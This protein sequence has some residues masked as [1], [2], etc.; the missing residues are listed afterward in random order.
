MSLASLFRKRTRGTYGIGFHDD[1]IA[2]THIKS[3]NAQS[4]S[5]DLCEFIPL[6]EGE[7]YEQVLDTLVN[8]YHLADQKVNCVLQPGDYS[9]FYLESPDVA[10]DEL[11][12]AIKWRI[13]DL[14]DFHID[15]AIID[16]FDIPGQDKKGKQKMMYTIVARHSEIQW[17][18]ELMHRHDLDINAIDIAELA[19]RNI[20]AYMPEDKDGCVLI[21]FYSNTGLI[22][23]TQNGVLHL[24]RSIPIGSNHIRNAQGADI[25][26]GQELTAQLYDLLDHVILEIQRSLDYFE[27]HSASFPIRKIVI[28]PMEQSIP[29]ITEYL[30]NELQMDVSEMDINSVLESSSIIPQSIQ[31]QCAAEIGAALRREEVSL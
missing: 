23:L 2:L 3:G 1:G 26:G 21:D 6:N 20:V 16:V 5:L 11:R 19:L 12:S 27:S 28:A 8:K 29:G 22:S 4:A 9:L 13:K 25:N 31:A 15:D 7:D 10:T 24:S 14:I 17:R 30:A 18:V